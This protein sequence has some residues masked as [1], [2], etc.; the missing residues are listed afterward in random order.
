[1]QSQEEFEWEKGNMRK[2]DFHFLLLGFCV[3]FTH[4]CQH[5]S[6]T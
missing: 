3:A 5:S 2:G 4:Y 6:Y 1:M